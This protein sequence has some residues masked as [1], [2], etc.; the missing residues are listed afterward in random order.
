[1]LTWLRSSL[2][3][4]ILPTGDDATPPL[5]PLVSPNG[6]FFGPPASL[7]PSTV[8]HREPRMTRRHALGV[9]S[10]LDKLA[11]RPDNRNTLTTLALSL[12]RGFSLPSRLRHRSLIGARNGLGWPR[13]PE[14]SVPRLLDPPRR[15]ARAS[16]SP[17]TG[18]KQTSNVIGGCSCSSMSAFER[19]P[20]VKRDHS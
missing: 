1:M 15:L 17:L 16:V 4:I 13:T 11:N 6:L 2:P 20:D 19:E 7:N 5:S 14:R 8:D 18:G 9:G 3:Q 12:W 10:R